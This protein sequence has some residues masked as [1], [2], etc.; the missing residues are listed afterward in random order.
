MDERLAVGFE[1]G[2]EGGA[3][4]VGVGVVASPGVE[5]GVLEGA[6][7]GKGNRPRERAV[8]FHGGEVVG[9]L[10]DG[11]S[12]REEYDAGELGRDVVFKNFGGGSADCFGGGW[13]GPLFAGEAHID[14]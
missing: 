9:G 2:F 6:G 5:C 4:G 1:A 12:T 3:G 10:L 14:F 7:K 13:L 11:L 8:L